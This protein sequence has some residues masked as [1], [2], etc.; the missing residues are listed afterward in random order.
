M[1]PENMVLVLLDPFA[2]RK[3]AFASDLL[4]CDLTRQ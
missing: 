2:K 1:G 4:G 3:R